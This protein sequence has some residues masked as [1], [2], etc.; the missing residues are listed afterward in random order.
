MKLGVITS[1]FGEMDKRNIWGT[2]KTIAEIGFD[3]VDLFVDPDTYN[4]EERRKIKTFIKD[5]GLEVASI[6]TC[7]D[8]W[9][10]NKEKRKEGIDKLIKRLDF[11]KE[12][13]A[14]N[15]EVVAGKQEKGIPRSIIWQNSVKSMQ[16]IAGYAE[17]VGLKIAVELEPFKSSLV[18]D[19]DTMLEYLNAVNSE[20]CMANLDI[21]HCH[22]MRITPQAIKRLEGRVV[23][24]HISDND[25]TEHNDW[26]PGR[27]TAD[28]KGYLSALNEIGYQGSVALELEQCPD[29]VAWVTE[30]YNY[31]AELTKQL[32]IRG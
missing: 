7:V 1:G 32:D 20:Y 17:R 26:P 9:N 25:G 15:V 16:E 21:S 6:T 12:M 23:H 5:A 29:P 24:V 13:D 4:P 18:Y 28:L 19:I 14:T 10:F 30:G 11:G 8:I 3:T 22:I 31:L 27:G 2:I